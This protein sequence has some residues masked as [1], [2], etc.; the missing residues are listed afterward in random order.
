MLKAPKDGH[1]PRCG[2]ELEAVDSVRI[3][4]DGWRRENAPGTEEDWDEVKE[5]F[6]KDCP[7][8]N[9]FY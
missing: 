5:G 8:C 4:N 7:D 6:I 9:Y 3:G 2:A 1:C